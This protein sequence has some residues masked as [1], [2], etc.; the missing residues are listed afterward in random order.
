MVVDLKHYDGSLRPID[1]VPQHIK[2]LYAQHSK[3]K[4]HGS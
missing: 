2:A 3:L 1:R 4:P